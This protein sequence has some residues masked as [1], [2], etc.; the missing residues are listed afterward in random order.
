MSI[1][2]IFS[3][4]ELSRLAKERFA[5]ERAIDRLDG[6]FLAREIAKECDEKYKNEPDCIRIA[7]T[8]KDMLAGIPLSIGSYNIFSGTQDDSFARSYALINPAF[9]VE[10][11]TGYCDPT[12]VF[13]DI[14]PNGQ[15][16]QE[17]IEALRQYTQKTEYVKNLN[18][19]YEIA[20][21]CTPEG[22]FFIEQVTGHLIP[23]VRMILS[24]GIDGI[25]GEINRNKA[26]TTDIEK[27]NYYDAM[28][29]SL[30]ALIVLTDRYARIAGEK[31]SKAVGKEK[32]KLDFM[33][34][35]LNKLK[36]GE[37]ESLYEAMQLFILIW[38]TMCLEQVPNPY[39]FSVGNIDRIFEPYREK[40]N[41]GRDETAALLKSF[42][43]F[44]NV[45]DRSWAISQN[46]MVSG[47][48][49]SGE[50][51]TNLTTYAV[52]DAYYDMNLPQPILSV[53]YHKN[54]P[55]ELHRELGKFFFS[56]GVLTPSLFNDESMFKV[57]E[58]AGIEREDLSDYSI[59][60]CQEPLI[61]GRDNGNTTN[62][63]LNLA[64]I[65]ELTINDG[66]SSNTRKKVGLNHKELGYENREQLLLHIKEA[67]K[68]HCEYFIPIMVK[69]ANA[70]SEAVSVMQV[71]FL[72]TMMGGIES[73]V[74][75]RDTKH[76]GTKY[77]GSGCLIHG[78]SVVADSFAA[79]E[80][81]LKEGKYETQ[82]LFNAVMT[83]FEGEEKLRRY[84]LCFP[85]YGN[86]IPDADKEA[87]ETVAEISTL[88]E[89]S[90]NYQGSSFRPDYATPSTHLLYG[91]KVGATPDGRHAREML[92]YGID[93]L[94]GEAGNGLGFRILSSFKLPYAKMC[95]G[96][97]SHF[98][99]DPKYFK[100]A[101]LEEKGLEFRD[102]VINPLFFNPLNKNEIAPFYLYVNVTT[103]EILRKV[104]A[105][106]K[107]YAPSGVYIVRIH[108]TF[109]NFL[110][111]SPDIQ[112][113]II[114]RLDLKST[115]I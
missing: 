29:I 7:K 69:A 27:Q 16:S 66:V 94:Y 71:P 8:L 17:R 87:A 33:E 61:M 14:L 76:K 75:T 28:L 89:N 96:Y 93:P 4:E 1:H 81:F 35:T 80:G 73:G 86:N 5:E 57:L 113:D 56:A 46:L 41:L 77:N 55:E 49:S 105:N 99:I 112:N 60:G 36:S 90:K 18:R 6:W 43:V 92:G 64:K 30:D 72:S 70:A 38:Q 21:E 67:F 13:N 25:R 107:K 9:S 3:N 63:W 74:D 97:A 108:G 47:K 85:K 26:L 53:K 83:D 104:L 31:A 110:D 59:A 11:F 39:A 65:L 109:V 103:P 95:G 78:L 102:K 44:F 52:L 19:A 115:A 10:S 34:E 84:M 2:S 40:E 79:I 82:R 45:A 48:S 51:L 111:L 12:A 101:S 37:V 20:G 54:T 106:P 98:G 50:D 100:G 58:L 68:K 22:V 62:S 23:D 24:S 91:Y 15:I 88:V 114:R 42:L 32:E